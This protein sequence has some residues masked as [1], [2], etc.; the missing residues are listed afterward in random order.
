[1]KKGY[2]YILKCSDNSYYTGST[3]DLEIRFEEHQSGLG[4]NYTKRRLP[5]ELIYYEEYDRIDEAF[6]R[7][8]QIQGWSYRKKQALIEDQVEILP[9]LAKKIFRKR[10]KDENH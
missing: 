2:M 4:S 7:E 9:Y 10:N 8:K 6:Y 1:M 3:T 5:V